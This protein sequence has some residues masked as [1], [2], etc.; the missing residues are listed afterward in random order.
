MT[1]KIWNGSNW[2]EYK[3]LKVF[4]GAWKDAAKGWINTSTGWRQWYPEYPELI[5]SPTITGSNIQGNT[6]TVSDGTWRGFPSDKAFSY[7]TTAYQWLRNGSNISGATGNQ[8]ATV[9][10]DIGNAI[11]C[12]VTV[13]NN[14]GPTPSTTSNSLT[15]Q[16]STYTLT[17]NANGGIVL[18]N[19]STSTTVTAGQSVSLPSASRDYHTFNGWYTSTSGGTYLGTTGNSYT[20]PSNITIYAQWSAISYSVSFNANGGSVSPTSAN[21]TNAGGVSLPTPSRTNYSFLGWYTASSGGTYVGGGGSV[22]YPTSSITLYAQWSIITYSVSWDANGGSVSPTSS[23]VNAGSSVTAPTPTRSGYTCTGWWNS[24]SGGT[25]IVDVG[26]SYTPSSSVTL[27]AQWTLTPI[28]PTIS[29]L[30]ITNSGTLTYVNWTVD[31]QDTYSISVSPST[32]GAGGG[33]SFSG[34][35]DAD[36]QKYIGTHTAGT[37]YNITLTVTSSTG[38]SDSEALSWTAPGGGGATAPSTPTN[39]VNTYSTGPSWTGTW[40]ASTGSTPITYYWTLYQSDS[41]GGAVTNSTSGN[42][43]GT[44]F[45]QAMPSA[46]GLWAYFTVYASNSAGNSS[47]ATSN[48]A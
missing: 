31:Y 40:T 25:K 38:H 33:T 19:P 27:Y 16:A 15:I 3:N 7:T 45:T 44:T 41:N 14:R 24:T 13:S 11:S 42:T 47:A 30:T 22:Y 26:A 8:Y 34:T 39:A 9:S 12:R 21:G 17:Y 43:T 29:S 10:A 2:K 23:S 6:L 20:P 36:R 46:Y 28:V 1:N 18:G 32:G 35:A 5:T 48:W 4:S 37:T